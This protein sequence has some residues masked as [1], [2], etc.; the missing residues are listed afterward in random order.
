M[1]VSGR[2]RV[3]QAEYPESA[4]EK[5]DFTQ[6]GAFLDPSLYSLC[7]QARVLRSSSFSTRAF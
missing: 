6:A 4:V 5:L 7:Q 3:V 1:L 2:E